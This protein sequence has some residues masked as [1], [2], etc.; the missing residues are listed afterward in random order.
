MF[1]VRLCGEFEELIETLGLQVFGDS[2]LKF[3]KLGTEHGHAK[4]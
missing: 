4:M 1:V 2:K 3:G